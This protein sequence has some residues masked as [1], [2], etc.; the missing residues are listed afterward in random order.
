MPPLQETSPCRQHGCG[1]QTSTNWGPA[2]VPADPLP[3]AVTWAGC[4]RNE[5][6][7]PSHSGRLAWR[8]ASFMTPEGRGAFPP[9]DAFQQ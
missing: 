5:G 2:A 1:P 8:L 6:T 4:H 3:P 9:Q 7:R